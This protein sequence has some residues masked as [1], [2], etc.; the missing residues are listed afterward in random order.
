MLQ[1]APADWTQ[2]R[3]KTKDKVLA[4][5]ASLPGRADDTMRDLM[6]CQAAGRPAD[7]LV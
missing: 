2:H 4:K 6:L 7:P 3:G 5:A 1:A